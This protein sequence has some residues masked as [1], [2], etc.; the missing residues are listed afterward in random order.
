M[1][2]SARGV[3]ERECCGGKWREGNELVG[4]SIMDE[5]FVLMWLG[6]SDVGGRIM[7]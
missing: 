2:S 3:E 7:G 5:M 4:G 1:D 6:D